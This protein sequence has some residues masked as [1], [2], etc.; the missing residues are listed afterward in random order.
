M[1]TEERLGFIGL[2]VM[3]RPMVANL[4]RA[5]FRAVVHSRTASTAAAAIELGASWADSPAA[6]AEQA[7]IVITM[8]PDTPDVETVLLGPQGVLA[9]MAAGTLVIDMSTIAPLAARRYAEAVEQR[10]GTFLDAPV[11][12]GEVGATQGTMTIMVGGTQEAFDR[13]LPVLEA[14]GR[15]ITLIGAHGAGQV[16]KACNQLIVAAN[17]EAVAEALVL[18]TAAGTDPARVRSA[19]L[20][21]FASS[22]VL[23]VHGQR[24][25]EHNFVPGFRARLHGKDARIILE[26]AHSLNC[27][28]PMFESAAA[29]LDRLIEIDGQLDHSALAVP[30]ELDAGVDLAAASPAA[31]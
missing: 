31:G 17:I 4:L 22:R 5:G 20:G 3:G 28:I 29:A 2:G 15:N 1:A 19:L 10:G 21:G 13:A 30:L 16:A 14:M 27:P 9:G 18:A 6:V 26:L 25:L 7:S 12:G 24:M 23:E 8:L 11:S